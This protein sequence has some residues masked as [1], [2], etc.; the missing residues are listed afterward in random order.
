MNKHGGLT[1]ARKVIVERQINFLNVHHN[2]F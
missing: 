2:I 1:N